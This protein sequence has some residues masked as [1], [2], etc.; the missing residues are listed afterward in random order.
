MMSNVVNIKPKP[1][2]CKHVGKALES[3]Y[4][5]TLAAIPNEQDRI[6]T[7]YDTAI[8]LLAR[9]SHTLE[10]PTEFIADMNVHLREN[11]NSFNEVY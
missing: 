2:L 9:I 4:N 10:D 6:D 8:K 11:I 5:Y 1:R 7:E 3:V